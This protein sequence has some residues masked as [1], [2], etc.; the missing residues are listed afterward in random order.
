MGG[1]FIC[2]SCTLQRRCSEL[3]QSAN[4]PG[5]GNRRAGHSLTPRVLH[6]VNGN[7]PLP[8]AAFG[9]SPDCG[10]LM[11]VPVGCHPN[12]MSDEYRSTTSA[13]GSS[14]SFPNVGNTSALPPESRHRAFMSTR[15]TEYAP[16]V[17][18]SHPDQFGVSC[19]MFPPTMVMRAVMLAIS[20]SATVSG[21]ALSTTR[22]A[23]RPGCS[24]PFLSS[25]NVR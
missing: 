14:A 23:N 8:I 20:S 1:Q 11:A 25:S 17:R 15:P 21:S 6:C 22:S 9:R 18:L 13:V 10:R 19:T 24:E 12:Q 2:T 4:R 7:P 16:N 3:L 5:G